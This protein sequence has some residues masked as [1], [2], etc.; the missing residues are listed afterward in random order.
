MFAGMNRKLIN[1]SAA[2]CFV[3]DHSNNSLPPVHIGSCISI[4]CIIICTAVS[5]KENKDSNV[6]NLLSMLDSTLVVEAEATFISS[7][8]GSHD[9]GMLNHGRTCCDSY[10]SFQK[11]LIPLST[12]KHNSTSN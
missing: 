3:A 4:N 12:L 5:N 1:Y 8:K 6:C 7:G 9:R 11:P 2:G 10:H